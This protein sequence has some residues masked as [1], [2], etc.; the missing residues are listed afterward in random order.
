MKKYGR[1][2]LLALFIPLCAQAA[3]DPAA[4]LNLD[5][6][7]RLS[8]MAGTEA[9]IEAPQVPRAQKAPGL[10]KV[11]IA[12]PE[13][14][15]KSLA[16]FRIVRKI[17][18]KVVK[19]GEFPSA[20]STH[21][22]MSGDYALTLLFANLDYQ[23]PTEMSLGD[24]VVEKGKT[25]EIVLGD[26]VFAVAEELTQAP[27]KA[28]IVTDSGIGRIVLRTL[29]HGNED[30]LFLPK[31]LLPGTYDVSLLY[32]RSETPAKIASG[33][34]VTAGRETVLTLNSGIALVRPAGA[35]VTGWDLLPAGGGEPVLSVRRGLDNEEPLWRPFLVPPGTYDLQVQVAG[36]DDA[37][38]VGEGIAIKP[39]QPVKFDLGL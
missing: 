10:G 31:V 5:A 14:A 34:E 6:P 1:I 17:S 23:P 25:A 39:G 29:S 4:A 35:A 16:G 15:L 3:H 11:R 9:K 27:V 38:L 20:D 36:R 2:W 19:E 21:S 26:L 28:M 37:L 13:R 22:L 30:D 32:R 24:F 8:G 33:L 18:D 7:S 12:F